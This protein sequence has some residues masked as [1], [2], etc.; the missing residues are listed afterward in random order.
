LLLAL[1]ALPLSAHSPQP[2]QQSTQQQQKASAEQRGTPAAPLVIEQI[3]TP[4]DSAEARQQEKRE[5][6]HLASEERVALWTMVLAIATVVLFI[7]TGFLV[8]YTYRLWKEA[9][10]SAATQAGKMQAAVE[11]ATRSADAASKGANAAMLQAKAIIH[12]ERPMMHVTAMGV[13]GLIGGSEDAP[14][15]NRSPRFFLNIN[16]RNFGRGPAIISRLGFRSAVGRAPPIQPKYEE[17][18]VGIDANAIVLPGHEYVRQRAISFPIAQAEHVAINEMTAS[19]WVWGRLVYKDFLGGVTEHGFIA[20]YQQ[21][22]QT[23]KGG[24]P[25]RFNFAEY[26]EY[27]FTRYHPPSGDGEGA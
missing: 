3:R 19:F 16:F 13:V 9:K 1:L 7:A 26:G 27:A 2:P 8:R 5:S 4:E 15:L 10:Y 12:L 14:G 21:D 23:P 22:I 18:G 20:R 25:A 17:I 24:V 6:Q 11:E